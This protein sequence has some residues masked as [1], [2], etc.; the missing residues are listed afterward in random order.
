MESAG[1]NASDCTRTSP[2]TPE[3]EGSQLVPPSRER[4]TPSSPP[5][6]TRF[7]SQGDCANA[8]ASTERCQRARISQCAPRSGETASNAPA[9]VPDNAAQS[10]PGVLTSAASVETT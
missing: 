2:G 3:P 4:K 8:R 9:P 6:T 10:L 7:G 1:S 5:Q